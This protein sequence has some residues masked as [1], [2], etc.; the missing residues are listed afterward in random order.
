MWRVLVHWPLEMYFGHHLAAGSREPITVKQTL[1]APAVT[2]FS[3]AHVALE[4]GANHHKYLSCVARSSVFY[5]RSSVPFLVLPFCW[6][7]TLLCSPWDCQTS[8]CLPTGIYMGTLTNKH[9]LLLSQILH[10]KSTDG[11]N[12]PGSDWSAA[13][14]EQVLLQVLWLWL[15]YNFAPKKPTKV[16]ILG[17]QKLQKKCFLLPLCNVLSFDGTD[18]ILITG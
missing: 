18:C 14:C 10:W 4:T 2:P 15:Q 5:F 9:D 3:V 6:Q 16:L 7:K 8:W 11:R 17:I 13:I 1:L 12:P